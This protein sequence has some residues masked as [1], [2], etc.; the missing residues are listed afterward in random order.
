MTTN[1]LICPKELAKF[2]G[3]PLTYIY[4]MVERKDPAKRPPVIR[5]GNRLRFDLEAVQAWLQKQNEPQ[6]E[7]TTDQASNPKPE[8]MN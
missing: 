8:L 6:P 2:L 4:R 5:L 3:M 7:G 1:K